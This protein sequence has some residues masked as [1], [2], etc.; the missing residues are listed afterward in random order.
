MCKMILACMIIIA[1]FQIAFF[2]SEYFYERQIKT[3]KKEILNLEGNKMETQNETQQAQEEITQTEVSIDPKIQH[4][5]MNDLQM[6]N[7][8]DGVR[9]I[10]VKD[11]VHVDPDMIPFNDLQMTPEKYLIIKL[12]LKTYDGWESKAIF[13]NRIMSFARGE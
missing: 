13:A 1:L 7:V 6:I 2:L 8:N 10:N 11:Y 4:T 9:M 5:A 12:M 3:L